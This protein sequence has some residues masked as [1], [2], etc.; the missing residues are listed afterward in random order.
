MAGEVPGTL[1]AFIIPLP[2]LYEAAINHLHFKRE[3]WSSGGCLTGPSHLARK[4]APKFERRSFDCENGK[5][6]TASV[7]AFSRPRARVPGAR[8]PAQPEPGLQWGGVLTV[9][10]SCPAAPASPSSGPPR[11][12]PVGPRGCSTSPVAPMASQ[13]PI[14]STRLCHRPESG[15]VTS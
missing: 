7:A 3:T 13:T 6:S 10:T 4:V 12:A 8:G 1:P 11:S 9:R 14:T 2:Q 15:A 5:P